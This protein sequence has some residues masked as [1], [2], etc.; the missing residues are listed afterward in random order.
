MPC[1]P[2]HG[3]APR[4][5]KQFNI[6]CGE[7]V[8]TYPVAKYSF[9]L[10][11]IPDI[12]IYIGYYTM[13]ATMAR[14]PSP[15]RCRSRPDRRVLPQQ[16]P[17][18]LNQRHTLLA[19]E[20]IADARLRAVEEAAQDAVKDAVKDAADAATQDGPD[21]AARKAALA[22]AAAER[23]AL[24]AAIQGVGKQTNWRTPARAA[25]AAAK[26]VGGD[27]AA[28]ARA[29]LIL[30]EAERGEGCPPTFHGA[31]KWE[32]W[33]RGRSPRWFRHVCGIS[34]QLLADYSEGRKNPKDAKRPRI[35]HLARHL[36]LAPDYF[37]D[38]RRPVSDARPHIY[39]NE[40]P[41]DL[42]RTRRQ[43]DKIKKFLPKLFTTLPAKEKADWITKYR[44][45]LAQEAQQEQQK[46][47]AQRNDEYALKCVPPR[48]EA[49]MA[50][51]FAF[52][53]PK[54]LPFGG[55]SRKEGL[56]EESAGMWREALL[57]FFG[58]LAHRLHELDRVDEYA[59][60]GPF[61]CV[62]VEQLHFGYLAAPGLI[63][64]FMRWLVARK[65][66]FYRAEGITKQDLELLKELERM[67]RPNAAFDAFERAR[68][69]GTSAQH[70]GECR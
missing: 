42:T 5:K 24:A 50:A 52:R 12:S 34:E 66:W 65:S 19:L 2:L 47:Q 38:R 1:L 69:A 14:R 58:F 20:K 29:L 55:N 18:R 46:L 11:F 37:W 35:E 64:A 41:A 21:V 48:L 51:F 25:L 17:P 67:S 39:R 13:Q 61:A 10:T 60:R 59:G 9:Q 3:P 40:L 43:T 70:E 62:P 30:D 27:Q 23:R 53:R 56:N 28:L 16:L 22:L 57:R 54:K 49:E 44:N 31:L 7:A 63:W 8:N 32:C 26:S 45:H 68:R 6:G 15:S 4:P 36:G 33:L